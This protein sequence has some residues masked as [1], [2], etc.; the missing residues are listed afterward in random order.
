MIKAESSFPGKNWTVKE[1]VDYY[2]LMRVGAEVVAAAVTVEAGMEAEVMVVV[3]RRLADMG[4]HR[5][6][7][8][9]R[10]FGLWPLL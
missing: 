4:C 6:S 1:A 3:E 10:L 7:T 5:R 9:C 2:R 8:L